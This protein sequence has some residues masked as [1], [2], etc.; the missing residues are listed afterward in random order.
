MPVFHPNDYFWEH[1]W[2]GKEEKWE[3][4]ARAIRNIISETAGLPLSDGTMEEKFKYKQLLKDMGKKPL[5]S[6]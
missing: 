2:D 3:A 4:F 1:H 5:K 6:D